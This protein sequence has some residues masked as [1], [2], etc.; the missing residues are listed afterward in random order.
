[1]L[2]P[3]ADGGAEPQG[4]YEHPGDQD[5]PSPQRPAPSPGHGRYGAGAR[6]H[7]STGGAPMSPKQGGGCNPQGANGDPIPSWSPGPSCSLRTSQPVPQ[8]ARG[9]AG[10]RCRHAGGSWSLRGEGLGTALPPCP[11]PTQLLAPWRR[12]TSLTLA[13]S[14]TPMPSQPPS[15]PTGWGA[16]ALLHSQPWGAGL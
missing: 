13:P 9:A 14:R 3:M 15:V 12:R 4:K 2:A 6:P 8:G 1:M 5:P 16:P 10:E 7:A 11:Q